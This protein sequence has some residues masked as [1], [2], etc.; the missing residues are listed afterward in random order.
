MAGE[1]KSELVYVQLKQDILN[2][3]LSPGQSLSAIDVGTR[4]SAS[5]TPVRQA[6]LRLEADGLVSLTDR[7]GARV[8]PI[9]IKS[10][11]DLFELRILLEAA[12]ARMVAE[13]VGRDAAAR[14]QFEEVAEALGA[15]SEEDPSESRRDRFYELTETYDQ[16]VIAH[17]R[18]S[19]LARSIAELRP[20]TE[21][22]RNI[23]H[24]HPERLD[25]SLAEHR[26]MCRAILAGD[27]PAAAA[28][29][30]EHLTQTQKTILDAVVDPQGSAVAIDLVTT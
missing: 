1:S 5:R 26:A 22:L 30:T 8:A 3:T 10:V 11:R 28:A 24:S 15:I 21:R 14:Q 12:A 29:C 16:A 2:G 13:A 4:F 6:F 18:N 25:V 19:Q 17:T 7:Q 9:S 20:H 27:G 23:A